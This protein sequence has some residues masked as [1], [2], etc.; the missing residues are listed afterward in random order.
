MNSGIYVNYTFNKQDIY[1]EITKLVDSAI[2]E[3]NLIAYETNVTEITNVIT[4]EFGISLS[5]GKTLRET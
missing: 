5:D 2:D 3:N 1:V 4:K